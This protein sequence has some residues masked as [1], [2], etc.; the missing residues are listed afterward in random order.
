MVVELEHP[1]AGKASQVGVAIKL[2]DTPGGIRR[3]PP[4][5]GEHTDEVLGSLGYSDSMLHEFRQS[6]VIL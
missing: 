6:G 5:L 2:S 3:L 4:L 1:E